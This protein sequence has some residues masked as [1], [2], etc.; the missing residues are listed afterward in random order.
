MEF[1][2]VKHQKWLRLNGTYDSLFP[3][4]ITESTLENSGQGLP[5][6]P[7]QAMW[8]LSI[9]FYTKKLPF[10]ISLH[11]I[12]QGLCKAPLTRMI[13][14]TENVDKEA[15][16]FSPVVWITYSVSSFKL[17]KRK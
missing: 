14:I 17:E 2:Y 5:P 9:Q 1:L 16:H 13:F 8:N 3:S 6:T 4:I 7:C 15:E 10:S 11:E 12:L